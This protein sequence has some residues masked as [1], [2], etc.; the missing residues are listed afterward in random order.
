V[1]KVLI[2]KAG[3]WFTATIGSQGISLFSPM[4]SK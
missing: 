3:C 4:D 2:A 1:L